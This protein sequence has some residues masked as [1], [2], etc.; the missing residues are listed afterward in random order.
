MQTPQKIVD[1]SATPKI[2]TPK[3]ID[4]SQVQFSETQHI[5][6]LQLQELFNEAAFWAKDRSLDDLALA[7]AHSYPITSA[8]D[9]DRLIGFART[10]SDRIY[11][12]TIWDVVVSPSHQGAGIGRKLIHTL[13][14]HPAMAKVERIYLMTT[15]QQEFYK[16]IGFDVN[17]STTMLLLNAP[18]TTP[19]SEP[20]T[21]TPMTQTAQTLSA[22]V[23]ADSRPSH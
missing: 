3:A 19:P 14:S 23:P 21:Q 16:R 17:P 11:R 4:C 22:G 5:D 9:G 2:S 12:G 10:T 6:L 8:W 13:L 1:S 20:M 18:I 7:L 15:Q